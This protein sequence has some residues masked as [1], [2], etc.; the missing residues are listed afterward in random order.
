VK[1]LIVFVASIT[2]FFLMVSGPTESEAVQ[3]FYVGC[4]TGGS[5]GVILGVIIGKLK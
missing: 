4:V 1:L 3:G 2:V 5:F